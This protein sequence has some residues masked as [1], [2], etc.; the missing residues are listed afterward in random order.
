MLAAS[1]SRALCVCLVTQ[2]CLTLFDPMYCVLSARRGLFHGIFQ[3]RILKWVA[4]FLL[5]GIYPTNRGIESASPTLAGRLFTTSATWEAASP[6]SSL[7]IQ[8]QYPS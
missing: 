4:M 8:T 2:M 1:A 6:D 7:V 5:Q 3:A